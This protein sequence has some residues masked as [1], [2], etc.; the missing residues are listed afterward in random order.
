MV[1]SPKGLAFAITAGRRTLPDD[2]F[3]S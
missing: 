1:F 2:S 3:A